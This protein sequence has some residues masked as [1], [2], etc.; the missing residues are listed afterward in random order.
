MANKSR[1][2]TPSRRKD[3]SSWASNSPASAV[4]R[5]L[6][7]RKKRSR[8]CRARAGPSCASLVPYPRAVSTWLMP[9]SSARSSVASSLRW[10]VG[11]VSA[12]RS[13]DS[14]K[15]MPPRENT[16]M[17]RFVRP[18]RRYFT[19]RNTSATNAPK[20]GASWAAASFDEVEVLAVGLLQ[21]A[22]GRG[23]HQQGE[24][25]EQDGGA[26]HADAG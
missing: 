12:P 21:L 25:A 1:Y 20:G 18:N 22:Q 26:A 13:H 24:G 16:E 8:G 9:S 4:A 17:S 5:I 7:C 23:R 19:G 2:S 6:L 14:W 11:E 15:R 3:S 10:L